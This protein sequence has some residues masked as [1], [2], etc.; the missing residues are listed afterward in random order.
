[1]IDYGGRVDKALAL[2]EYSM[3]KEFKEKL[4]DAIDDYRYREVQ[5]AIDESE[6][7]EDI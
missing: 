3:G 2:V 4:E 1:M 6:A 5:N 7:G